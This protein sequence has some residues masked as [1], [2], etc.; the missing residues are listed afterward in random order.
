MGVAG[1][2]LI[3]E[4]CLYDLRNNVDAFFIYPF[5][6]YFIY[7]QSYLCPRPLPLPPRAKLIK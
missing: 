6:G 5:S 2:G 3:N 4:D 7:D 1:S